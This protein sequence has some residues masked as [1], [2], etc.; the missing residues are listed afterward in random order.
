MDRPDEEK[1]PTNFFR[2]RER[3][4]RSLLKAFFPERYKAIQ[5]EEVNDLLKEIMRELAA[6]APHKE[7]HD[8]NPRVLAKREALAKARAAKAAKKG[9][10]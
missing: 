10:A 1:T 9:Q 8:R 3:H 7:V 6:E 2:D 4:Q 5:N